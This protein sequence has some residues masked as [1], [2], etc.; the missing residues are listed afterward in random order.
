MEKHNT[1]CVT[2]EYLGL[3]PKP[4]SS[5]KNLLID[6]ELSFNLQRKLFYD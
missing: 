1:S 3:V 6:S 4:T 2:R 5:K